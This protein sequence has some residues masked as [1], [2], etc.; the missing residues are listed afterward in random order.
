[1]SQNNF[2]QSGEWKK[3]Q[4]KNGRRAIQLSSGA[5]GFVHTLPLVGNYL[6]FPRWPSENTL[7]QEPEMRNEILI[8]LVRIAQEQKAAWV[9]IEP[10]TEGI[11]NTLRQAQDGNYR[12]AKAPH[13]MQPRE[14]FI[15]DITK[16]EE[17]LLA[18]MK[19]KVRYNIRLAEKKGVRVFPSREKKYQ[20]A[21]LSLVE[22][23]AKRQHILPHP[24]AYYENFFVAIRE[25]MCELWVAEYQGHILAANLVV[26]AGDTA[27]YLHGGTS[28]EYRDVMAP[29]LLQWAQIQAAKRRGLS[30]YDFGGIA[31]HSKKKGWEGITR[32]KTGFSPETKPTV[33][34]GSYDIILNQK[35][36]WLYDRLRLLQV[37]L[38]MMKKIF[39]FA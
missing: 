7:N 19:P 22:S 24:R 28:D 16:T 6:Y 3:F 32:F 12:I 14:N 37:G 13:D 26:S 35:K 34:P 31:M 33:Y 20:E 4:E 18:G 27:T 29:I 1:M 8:E 38:S 17:E 15:I 25:E 23:T 11:T 21:F 10:E 30:R 2:L 36:Y 39:R 5:V 9:R